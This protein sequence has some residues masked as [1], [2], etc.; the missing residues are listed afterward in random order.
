MNIPHKL[1]AA[2]ISLML[3]GGLLSPAQAQEAASQAQANSGGIGDAEMQDIDHVQENYSLK[4][5]F[6]NSAGE[7]LA[8]VNVVIHDKH[9]QVVLDSHAVGPVLLVK[10]APG[11][12][13]I[14]AGNDTETKNSKV[15]VHKK[16]IAVRYIHLSDS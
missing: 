2:L 4:L 1:P 6:A 15:I 12:Y 7:Y 16:G 5:V 10:L 9:G 14:S 3:C 13:N 11:A 8:D